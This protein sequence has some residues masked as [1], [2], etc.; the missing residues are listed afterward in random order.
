MRI[1]SVYA[2][3][4]TLSYRILSLSKIKTWFWKLKKNKWRCIKPNWST[5]I[6]RK[7]LKFLKMRQIRKNLMIFSK[8]SWR[9]KT[10]W[11]VK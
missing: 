3:F 4:A 9:R 2:I 6:S 1:Y 7:I 5:W 8:K 10:N 11:T